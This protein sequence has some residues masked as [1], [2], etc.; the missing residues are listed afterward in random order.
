MKFLWIILAAIAVFFIILIYNAV[1][2]KKNG[3]KLKEEKVHLSEKQQI[4]YAEKLGKMIKCETVSVKGSYD[5]T[6]F[7]KLRKTMAELFP[8]IHEKAE[9]MT[10]GDDCWIFKIEGKDKSRNIMLMSHHDVV[11]ANG[12]WKHPPFCGEIHDGALWGR[13]TV[14][15]KTSL[16]AEFT[17]V[18]ELL[19]E[20]FVPECNLYIGSSHNEEIFGD[21]FALAV[22]Y[23]K[24]NGIKFETVLDEGGGIIDPP[25]DFVKCKCAM[26]ATHEKGR[27]TLV[28]TAKQSGETKA[29]TLSK[30][31]P[32]VRMAN[33]ISEISSKNIF[34]SRLYPVVRAMFEGLCPY[35]PFIARLVCANLWC[36]GG[37]IKLLAP[38]INSQAASMLGT[39]MTVTNISGTSKDKIC[40]ADIYLR[41]IDEND[42][43]KDLDKLKKIAAKHGVEIS[44][45]GVNES[46]V[47]ADITQKG[48]TYTNECIA[49]IFPN[50]AS[51]VYLLPAG[52]DARHMTSVCNCALRFAPLEM[53]NQQFDSVHNPNENISLKAIGNA[54]VFYKHFVKNYK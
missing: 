12:E 54:V 29:F 39:T 2:S 26:I 1:K 15:T 44:E 16:F 17:A 51:S 48:F 34:I 43:E 52:T 35:M 42:F 32:T 49:E 36:F 5:D 45:G 14:D 3:R 7:A 19:A 24:N 6:E 33:F 37:I 21:G 38:K 27:R 40:K 30:N 20:G 9:K 11:A 41:F 25:V 8:L 4:E 46:Y 10:F 50:F 53:N 28:C 22:E 18:E 47:P 23:F 13:G 31:P